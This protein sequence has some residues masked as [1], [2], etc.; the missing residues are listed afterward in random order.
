MDVVPG[1]RL[2]LS[3]LGQTYV[4]MVAVLA[5]ITT[6]ADDHAWYVAL[7]ALS[8]PLS[9]L[10]L[11]VGVYAG[12]AVGLR[13]RARR[14]ALPL[15]RGGGVGGGLDD[16]GLAERAHRREGGAARLAGALRV[17]STPS[18][19]DGA[20]APPALGVR[21]TGG[22]GGVAR[23]VP[24]RGLDPPGGEVGAAARAPRPACRSLPT[25]SPAPG[26]R[27]RPRPTGRARRRR[28]PGRSRRPSRPTG[29]A[30]R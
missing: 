18:E 13:R 21:R 4:A 22:P 9:L 30:S 23:D 5:T 19:P 10:A 6:F 28:R 17:G 7:I 29:A 8:L 12:L 2:R 14:G 1:T 24:Q 26:A 16:D 3:V 15:D 20:L 11:W 25:G 27:S